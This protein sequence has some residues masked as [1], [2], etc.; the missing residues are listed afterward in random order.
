MALFGNYDRP[1]RGVLKTPH[2]KTG[3]FKFWEIYFRIQ[4]FFFD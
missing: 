4:R 2:E 3:F 1:G